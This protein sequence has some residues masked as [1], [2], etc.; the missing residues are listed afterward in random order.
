MTPSWSHFKRLLTQLDWVD[1]LGDTVVWMDGVASRKITDFAGE[2]DSLDA[3]ELKAYAPVKRVALVPCLV[4]KARMR[5]RDDLATMLCKRIGTKAKRA[6]EE[7]EAIRLAEREITEALIGNYRSV[8]KDIDEDGPAHVALAKATEMTA[9]A[10]AALEGLD[11][12]A[13]IEEIAQRLDGEVSPAVL[14]LLVQ[15]GG[16][17]AVTKTVEGFGGFA[18]Q[19]EQIEKVSA[20]HGNFWE[21]LL[22][23][24]IGRDRALMFDLAEKLEFTVT[25]ED[26]RVLDALAHAQRNEAARGEYISAL[27]EDGEPVDISFATQ[28][29]QKAVVDR[30]RP[31]QFV[32]RHFEA[33]VFTY[34]AEELR[35]GDV[36]VVGSE[37]YADWSEQ[38]LAWEV[39][40]ETLGS[41]LVEVGLAD[42]GGSAEF[43]A[44]FFRR[45]LEDKLRNAAAAADAGYPENDGLVI[46]P[47]TGIPSLKAFRADGQRPSVKR[48]EQEMKV[49][50]PERSLMGIVAR[51]AY[52]V[53]WWRRFGPPSGN[54]P[55]L[56]DPLGRYVIVTFVKG[57]SMGPYEAARHIPGVSGHELSYVANKHFSIV[58]LN[59]AVADLVNAHARL[60]ISQAWG[61]GTAVAADGTHMDTYLDNLLSETSVRYGKP[62]GIA[63]HHVSDT[64]IALFTHFIPCGVW[65]AVYIIEGLLKNTSE[66]QPTTVHA[67]TQGQSFPVFALA[68]LLGFDLMPRIRNWKELTFYRPSKQSEY[69]HIDA[70]FGEPGKQVIDFDLIESQVRHLMRVAVSVREGTISSS[71]LL[72]RLRSGSRK[73][74]TYAAFREVGEV[75]RVIRTVQLRAASRTRRCAGG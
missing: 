45:Q 24:R 40:Q 54:E 57:T 28:N 48:L 42:P 50:M 47:E 20:H 35:T 72:K 67:D 69:V 14:A 23:G 29:W 12:R 62:G 3:S 60:D 36:A 2:A 58:L 44:K 25:S 13:P 34:L 73:N 37:E 51:T 52:W 59:E 15:S 49:R 30:S 68:H 1:A 4:H 32:R 53:E 39:V 22:Y 56:T 75:G 33:M 43:D 11:E 19:Y 21:V 71:T 55:K 9:E 18:K 64:Y 10:V 61:D 5:V 66:V 65:E 70:L 74:A 31:G 16:L 17:G 26:G 63:Y 7:L 46:D 8:L 41:Y 38:L 6:K 27:G